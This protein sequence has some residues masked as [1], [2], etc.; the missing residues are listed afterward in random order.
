MFGSSVKAVN[1]ITVLLEVGGMRLPCG[2]EFIR[3]GI[4]VMDKKTGNKKRKSSKTKNE[5][6]REMLAVCSRKMHFEYVLED[7]WFSSIENMI[8]CKELLKNNLIIALKSNRKVTL[9]LGR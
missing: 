4:W 5:I 8:Y 2:L 7:S 9:S 1:F 6:F 3:K